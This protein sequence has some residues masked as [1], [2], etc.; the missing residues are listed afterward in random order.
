MN[1]Q[2]RL[3]QLLRAY[4]WDQLPEAERHWVVEQLSGEDEYESLRQAELELVRHFRSTTVHADEQG[5]H[6]L[7]DR[8][9]IPPL[10]RPERTSW[11]IPGYAIGL[12]ATLLVAMGW[13]MGTQWSSRYEKPAQILTRLDTVRIPQK[14][15]TIWLERV[16]YRPISVSAITKT[17]SD[18]K[19]VMDEPVSQR[20]VTM[21]EKEALEKLLVSGGF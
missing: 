5:L 14:P 19:P 2:D 8:L 1:N 10:E 9:A 13:W 11:P 16:V 20:G 6:K 7:R 12:A 18:V 15:D 21:K 3:E 17:Q 4:R